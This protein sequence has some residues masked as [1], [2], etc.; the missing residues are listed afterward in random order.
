MSL[1]HSSLG[2]GADDISGRNGLFGS[3]GGGRPRLRQASNLSRQDLVV[4]QLTFGKHRPQQTEF[5]FSPGSP[6]F[7]P[8]FF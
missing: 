5:L 6:Y 8:A 2:P 1:F 3:V 4:R 7:R